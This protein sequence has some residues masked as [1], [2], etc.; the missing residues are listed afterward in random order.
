MS[1]SRLNNLFKIYVIVLVLGT[2]LVSVVLFFYL[3]T[4]KKDLPSFDQLEKYEP[5]LITKVYSEDNVKIKEFFEEKRNPVDL[6][7][8]PPHLIEALIST[9]DREFYHHWGFNTLATIR[10]AMLNIPKMLTGRKAHGASTITQQLARNLYRSIG[11]AHSIERKIKELLTAIDLEKMYSKKEILEMYFTQSTF[12][13]GVYGIQSGAKYFFGKSA[14][15]LNILESALLVAQL[16]AP[17]HY[18]PYRK[19]ERAFKRRN[20]VLHN[21]L[22]EGYISEDD[23]VRYIRE[24]IELVE[25]EK[26][27]LGIAPYFTENVRKDLNKINE[28]Y[29][30]D[31]LNDGLTIYTTLD[32][33][34]QQYAEDAIDSNIDFLTRRTKANFIKDKNG[35]HKYVRTHYDSLRWEYKM[36]DSLMID[37]IAEAKLKPEFALIAVDPRNGH[38]KAMVG[39][40]DFNKTKYNRATQAFR[41]PGSIFKPILYLSAIDNGYSPATRI[42]NQPLVLIDNDGKRWSPGNFNR[43]N[44][45]GK[46][47]LRHALRHSLNTV[48]ARVI[49]ELVSPRE[50]VSYAK[51]LGINTR[52]INPYPSI[53]LGS[54]AL[55]PIDIV[56]AYATIANKGTMIKPFSIEKIVDRS[57]N[58]IV[59][60]IP[61]KKVALSEETSFIITDMMKDVVENGTG[62]RLGWKFGLRMDLAGKTGTTNSST[63]TWF[64]GFTPELAVVVWVGLDDH[65]YKL[66][67]KA[68]GS[69]TALEV[70]GTFMRSVFRNLDYDK[71]LKFEK[72]DGVIE[73]EVCKDTYETAAPYCPDTYTEYFNKKHY[74]EKICKKHGNSNIIKKG[75]RRKRY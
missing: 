68:T 71:D 72:P 53:A 59:E 25:R 5:R 13:P 67:K 42:L 75:G 22:V 18:N 9:E 44:I 32:S 36:T 66:G 61:E 8:L 19:P 43:D 20:L 46:L 34:M 31:Y 3:E 33:R 7:L 29:G 10:A 73:V 69:N 62:K 45:G 24:P 70:W 37:S 48:S 57:G 11:F 4:L 1:K 38:I 39:G 49:N 28:E 65:A 63:D 6:D 64:C 23:Y 55:R 27:G 51:R 26:E 56:T 41:Q 30:V 12:G 40:S 15:D 16:K 21:M 52:Y 58:T 17:A 60:N 2:L 47:S 50:V 74:R 35:L 54:G 14:Y